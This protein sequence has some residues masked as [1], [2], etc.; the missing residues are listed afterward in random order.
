MYFARR[1]NGRPG[2]VLHAVVMA[3]VEVQADRRRIDMLHELFELIGR[4]DEQARLRFDQQQHA[5]PS[6]RA[7]RPA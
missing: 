3:D 7:R 5:L 2:F 4:L 1:S 6:P